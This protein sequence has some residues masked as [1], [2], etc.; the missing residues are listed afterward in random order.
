MFRYME[1]VTALDNTSESEDIILPSVLELKT[2]FCV[3][4]SNDSCSLQCFHS[5]LLYNDFSAYIVKYRE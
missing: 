3:K 5:V 4:A 2:S 1:Q